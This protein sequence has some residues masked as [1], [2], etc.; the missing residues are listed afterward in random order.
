VTVAE[1]AGSGAEKSLVRSAPFG[2]GA[3]TSAEVSLG[4]LI[5]CRAEA[6]ALRRA[7]SASAAKVLL[8]RLW[9]RAEAL[10]ARP[11]VWAGL[12]RLAGELRLRRMLTGAQAKAVYESAA[13]AARTARR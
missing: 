9:R 10:L 11:T 13:L 2:S 12:E 3:G 6:L 4:G 8:G 7:G 5:V 1:P